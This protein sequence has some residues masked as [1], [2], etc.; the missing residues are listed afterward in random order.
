M[1]V[2]LT[3]IA[4]LS[5]CGADMGP[6]GIASISLRGPAGESQL[7]TIVGGNVQLHA[8]AMNSQGIA[9]TPTQ[10]FSFASKD[11]IVAS[12]SSTGLLTA[13][14][15]GSTFVVA[16]LSD[17]NESFVDSLQVSVAVPV[18]GRQP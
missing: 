11:S 16:H 15:P 8:A 14:H 7:F 9:V 2:P 13:N 5:A 10:P 6:T 3:L 17:G 18:A 12:I 1:R 4:A